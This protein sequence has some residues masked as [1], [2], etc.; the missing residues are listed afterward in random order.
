MSRLNKGVDGVLRD[1]D[2]YRF[3]VCGIRIQRDCN[4]LF[5]LW[6]LPILVTK[7]KR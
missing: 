4:Y 7:L 1:I 3:L 5:T 2:Q 6:I